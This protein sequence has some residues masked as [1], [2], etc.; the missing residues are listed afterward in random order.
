[1]TDRIPLRPLAWL[2]IAMCLACPPAVTAQQEDS[3]VVEDIEIHGLQRITEGTLYNYLP[4]SIGDELTPARTAQ[5]LRA[6]FATAFFRDVEL[7]RDGD[8]LVI[9][10]VERPTIAH[11]SVEGNKDIKDEELRDVLR[12]I[13]LAEGR[14]FNRS[15]LEGV[16][17]ELR[18]QYFSNGK[19]GVTVDTTLTELENNTVSIRIDI[20]E[21]R[22][23]RIKRIN[24]VGNDSFDGDSLRDAL[25]LSEPNW[26]S[27][28]RKDDQYS[29]EKLQGDLESL[30]S[31]YMDRGYA[32]FDLESVQVAI[33]PD[34]RDMYITLAVNEGER[35]T[36]GDNMEV[37]GELVVPREELRRLILPQPGESFARRR[38]TETTEW[39]GVRLGEEGYANAEISPIPEF[40]HESKTVDFVFFVQPGRR[41]FVRRIEFSGADGTNDETFRREMRQLEGTWLRTSAIERS[42]VRLQ[43][44]PF[45]EEVELEPTP[46][47]GSPDLVDLEV[48]I[49]ERTPGNFNFGFGYS[50]AYGLILNTGITH[51]NFLGEGKRAQIDLNRSG[52]SESYLFN[53]LD[54]YWTTGGINRSIGLFYRDI[55]QLFAQGSP[56]FM[57]SYGL[58]VSFGIPTSEFNAYNLGIAV[59]DSEIVASTNSSQTLIDWVQNPNHGDTFEDLDPNFPILNRWGTHF[60]T[61]EL[62]G[63]WQH[64]TR[65]RS[66][67]A[68]R[69]TLYRATAEVA[70]PPSE[71]TYAVVGLRNE[72]YFPLTDSLT[73]A[74]NA[75]ANVAFGTGSTDG[76]PPYKKFFG[77]GP[78]SVRGYRESWL[79]PLDATGRPEGGSIRMYVQS[80]LILPIP[81]EA[82]KNSSRFSLF[83]DVGN[84]FQNRNEVALDEL[85]M[86]AGIGVTWLAPMGAMKFSLA[87]AINPQ[88]GDDTETFQFT[89]GSSF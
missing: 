42:K 86:S 31:W 80:E 30:R 15:V 39:M 61:L 53:Y 44:L 16:E 82:L 35:Y 77:G 66:I 62:T 18:R 58:S 65:N 34:K 21:G 84:V 2:P 12:G 81:M 54:P 23:A 63:G 13:G 74:Y 56:F 68:T 46:V 60:R 73:L 85:R 10:V 57:N 72:R 25:E 64:D 87:H 76:A 78:D 5:A 79:G 41:M 38:V 40:D 3:F 55:D 45:V 24:F 11:F 43:R 6:L 7:R 89:L 75:E 29:R 17:V 33:S 8:T 59:R 83:F 14:I 49:E 70:V 20:S 71:V 51:A 26:L 37:G 52:F 36:F 19:Y 48:E 27:W 50:D 28:Y 88:P 32:N 9:V 69:G 4:V 47:P 22:A 1:M 67:F